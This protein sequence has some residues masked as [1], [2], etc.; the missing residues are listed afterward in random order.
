MPLSSP[1]NPRTALLSVLAGALVITPLLAQQ[2]PRPSRECMREIRQMCGTGR[3]QVRECLRERYADLS[4]DCIAELRERMEARR[5]SD[6]T[7]ASHSLS[8]GEHERQR[9]DFYAPT[10]RD[11]GAGLVVFIHGGGWSFG[12]HSRV[13]AK[14]AH[15]T[16]QGHAF[17]S[18]G[19]R[20]LPDAPVEDQAADVAAA[21]KALRARAETLGFDPDRIVLMGHSAG[22]H[23]AALVATDPSYAGEAF[24]AIRG[25]V[26]LDG[27]GYDVATHMARDDVQLRRLYDAAFGSDPARQAALSPV[28]HVGGP[29]APD[30][31]VLYV[32]ER[33]ASRSQ[34][35]MLASR[36]VVAGARAEAISIAN[37]DHG[38]MNREIGTDA[39]AQQTSAVDAFL[40]RVLR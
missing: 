10:G 23:L 37:T 4:G 40:A 8:Y 39:G 33:D 6:R 16:D 3:S 19:Y 13:Q 7:Q 18:V 26:L 25:V 5:G 36:L 14:P 21:V 1:V 24:E 28:T 27:A 34:S 30:W 15:F 9:I 11:K 2:Q 20:V 22:A 31:L 12:N 17:A 38:R 29:D 32:A 35:E